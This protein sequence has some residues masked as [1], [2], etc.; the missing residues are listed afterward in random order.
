MPAE[1]SID[2]PVRSYKKYKQDWLKAHWEYAAFMA[3]ECSG[4][5]IACSLYEVVT[6]EVVRSSRSKKELLVSLRSR[7]TNALTYHIRHSFAV[8]QLLATRKQQIEGMCSRVQAEQSVKSSC[9]GSSFAD[10]SC[11]STTELSVHQGCWLSAGSS[12]TPSRY[13]WPSAW[14]WL[15]SC[16]S[17]PDLHPW[18]SGSY[19]TA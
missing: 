18:Q 13:G 19:T 16:P 2:M 9:F 6:K 12:S 17:P 7:W 15:L 4:H 11:S 8:H 10:G 5:P 3:L 1:V 14:P